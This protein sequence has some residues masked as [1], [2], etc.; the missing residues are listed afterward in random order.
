MVLGYSSLV[1]GYVVFFVVVITAYDNQEPINHDWHRTNC[2]YKPKTNN[3]D[4]VG[5]FSGFSAK[6]EA[7]SCAS[8]CCSCC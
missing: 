7:T 4:G 5:E 2:N 8:I 6:K 1:H 3:H